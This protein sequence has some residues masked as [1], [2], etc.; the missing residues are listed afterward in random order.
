MRWIFHYVCPIAFYYIDILGTWYAEVRLFS[1]LIVRGKCRRGRGAVP[2]I[3]ML[4]L[5]IDGL[6]HTYPDMRPGL[7]SPGGGEN[8]VASHSCI[9][10][11]QPAYGPS[12]A[13]EAVKQ[14]G[15]SI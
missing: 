8:N 7:I 2:D 4:R 12:P 9:H 13:S 5:W 15:S 14:S 1:V 11:Q 10:A 6:V 3:T